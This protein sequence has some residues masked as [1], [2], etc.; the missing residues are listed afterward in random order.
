[1]V[2]NDYIKAN[3]DTRSKKNGKIYNFFHFN[4]M[5][6]RECNVFLFGYF[7]NRAVKRHLMPVKPLRFVP[8]ALQQH[9]ADKLDPKN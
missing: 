5:Q 4:E 3:F 1:M 7:P 8:C 6:P 2:L 9:S